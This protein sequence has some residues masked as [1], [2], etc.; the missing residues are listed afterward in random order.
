MK[1]T[2]HP[3]GHTA[4]TVAADKGG[5]AVTADVDHGATVRALLATGM[6]RWDAMLTLVEGGGVDPRCIPGLEGVPPDTVKTMNLDDF[7]LTIAIVGEKDPEGCNAFVNAYLEGREVED[8][9]ELTWP[10]LKTL[11]KGLVVHGRVE[12]QGSGV[13]AL[14]DGFKVKGCLWL[15]RTP[16]AALPKGLDVEE[17]LD[18]RGCT[19]WDGRIPKDARIGYRQSDAHNIFTDAHP[20]GLTVANWRQRYPNGEQS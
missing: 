4:R 19:Q 14:P 2:L 1:P 20:A 7:Y 5:A 11:P 9:L 6:L 17:V 13:V 15:E 3:D 8:D 10:W 16:I 18:L 12:L